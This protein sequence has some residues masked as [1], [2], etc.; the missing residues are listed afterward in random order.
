MKFEKLIATFLAALM[1]IVS[2][3]YPVLAATNLGQYPGFLLNSNGSLNTLIVVGS[4]ASSQDV[5][6]A[7]DL[8]TRLAQSAAVSVSVPGGTTSNIN[9]LEKNTIDI[10]MGNMTD[11]FPNPIRSFH[12]NGLQ[13][14]T[15]SYKGNTYNYHEDV[16]LANT[17]QGVF[18]SHDFATNYIN[19]TETMVVGANMLAYEYVFDSAINCTALATTAQ[20]TCTLTSLE[21]TNPVKIWMAGKPFVI[22]GIGSNQVVMLS[23]NVGTATA[24]SGVTAP[25]GNYTVYSDLGNN[26]SWGRIIV[27]DGSG[28]TVET[29]VINQGDSF[30]FTNEGFT[31]KVTNVRALQDGTVVGVDV[32]AGPIGQTTITYT[33]SCSIGGTGSSNF[34]FP[35]ETNWCIQVGANKNGGTSFTNAGAIAAGDTIQVVYKPS[36]TQYFKWAGSTITL[37]LPNSYGEVGFEGWN[38]NTFATLTFKYISPTTV[39]YSIGGGSTNSTPVPGTTVSGV[40]VDSDTAGTLVDPNTN[41]GY[42]RVYYLFNTTTTGAGTLNSTGYVVLWGFWDSTNNRIGVNITNSTTANV[43][44]TYWKNLNESTAGSA[45]VQLSDYYLFNT[46]LSYGGGAAAKDQLTLFVNMTTPFG[47]GTQATNSPSNAASLFSAFAIVPSSTSPYIGSACVSTSGSVLGTECGVLLNWVNTTTTWSSSTSPTFR[48]Y[49]TDSADTHDIE[50]V[51]TPSGGGSAIYQDIGQ[52]V[53][54]VVSNSGVIVSAPAN[55]GSN[56][57][58]VKLPAQALYVKAYVGKAGAATTTT[59]GTYQQPVPIT[60][61]VARLDSEIISSDEASSDLIL[62]GGPCVNTL[63][64]QLATA[65]GNSSAMYPYTCASWPG[66]NFG[67][68]RVID[69]AFSTGHQVLVVAGTTAAYTRMAANVLQQYDTL[70]KGQTSQNVEVTSLSA[71]GITAVS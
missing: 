4:S 55:Q 10:N 30:D 27:K 38:Y 32:V 22:V 53:Q 50:V 21:Y 49:T 11:V 1:S 37:P 20:N 46:T 58:T 12:Y 41:T 23:G 8:A 56:V 44:G 19:G 52:A 36:S 70:L 17:G 14:G 39:Y 35:G 18:F 3:A 69:N 5:I 60:Q 15:L 68:I 57:A 40:E 9:G 34:N 43:Y 2:V 6:A 51:Q 7:T 62:V 63:V 26:G 45:A 33:T 31:V 61:S 13:T 48:L 67:S 28:N 16:N 25:S 42:S 47:A 71:S 66:R 29:R 64:A 54:D 24:T 65:S 59:G